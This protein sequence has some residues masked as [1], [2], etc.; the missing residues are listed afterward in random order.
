M[1]RGYAGHFPVRTSRYLKSLETG[2]SP[3]IAVVG[4][5]GSGKS[6]LALALAQ[7][8][9]GE[10]VSCDSIQV[11]RQLNIGSAKLLPDE[12][13]GVPHHLI[14]VIDLHEELTAGAYA[15]LARQAIAS[16]SARGR[17]PVVVGGTG[18]YLRA[19][20]DGLSP[21]PTRNEK[22]RDRLASVGRGRPAALHRL[23]TLRD[24]VAAARI[25]A[26][27]HQKLIRA[28]ELSLGTG[29]RASEW[30]ELPRDSLPGV[31]TLKLGLAPDR[32]LLRDS[33]DRRTERMFESGLLEETS[34]ILARGFSP[35]AKPLQSLGYKQAVAVLQNA[36][37]LNEA[38]RET[39][40]RTRQY[41]KRQM[42]WFRADK[43]VHW[44]PGFG[45]DPQIQKQALTRAQTFLRGAGF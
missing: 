22:M 17:I 44:L 28:L 26:N 30:Q 18:F 4:P 40:I 41:S 29:Q 8:I 33:I 31:T 16:I 6:L 37:T 23:L 43:E 2:T 27:D 45:S 12:R 13:L 3:L 11:Y 38:V 20:L 36:L 7:T 32:H 14:D 39:Q 25:H 19:L 24:P 42:T 5:T 35:E 34:G 1:C 10:I 9:G 15:R 21:A